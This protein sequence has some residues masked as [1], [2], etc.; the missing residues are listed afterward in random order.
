MSTGLDAQQ[1]IFSVNPD[2]RRAFEALEEHFFLQGDWHALASVYRQRLSAASIVADADEQTQLLY[3]LGQL[4]EER[5]VDPE[6]AG[7][8]YWKLA[9]LDPSNRPVLRQLRGIHE[10]L[11]QWDLVLQI[12]ELEGQTNMPP[13]ERAA[14][15]AEVG[16]LWQKRL[17]DPDEARRAFE[18]SLAVDPNSS[19]ALQGLAVLH[20]E[21]GRFEDAA[22]L[23]EQLTDRLRGPERAPVWIAL[24]S[25]FAGPLEDP[26]RAVECFENALD[27][28]PLQ[29]P[30]VEGALMLETAAENWDAV[31][32]LLESR[33][34]L[35]AG[36]EQRAAIALEAS[37]IQLGLLGS[38]PAARAW[39]DRAAALDGDDVSMLLARA[40][41]DRADG[42]DEALLKTLIQLTSV[43]GQ[44]ASRA[45]LMEMDFARRQVHPCPT[46]QLSPSSPAQGKP[47]K[48]RSF[49]SLSAHFHACGARWER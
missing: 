38:A 17:G 14:L 18:R 40:D 46:H 42:D 45:V 9:K 33:F 43:A 23:L 16:H 12:A 25:L 1:Q 48:T 11:E 7:E 15:E 19:D 2:D 3:R 8:V 20:R 28:D 26:A 31:S 49:G 39:V 21:A 22:T 34:D 35:A 13:A 32:A 10:Q 4:L 37:Q 24:G 47:S 6:A 44:R 36:E 29:T 41:I 27:D 30:A 5:I